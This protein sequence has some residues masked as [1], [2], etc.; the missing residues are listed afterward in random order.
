MRV[1]LAQVAPALGNI[2]AN[3][4]MHREAT[5]KAIAA[6][7]DLIVFPELSLTGYLLQDLV[8]E[9]ALSPERSPEVRE[10]RRLSRRIAIVFGFVEESEDHRFYNAAL[11]LA[12]GRILHRHRKVYL[13]TYGM[14]E[15]GREFAAGGGFSA[16]DTP[17]GRFGILLCEDAWHPSSAYL[18][19]QDGADYLLVLSSGPSRGV[20]SG[21]EL[22]STMDWVDL[23]RVT[24]RFQTL[25]VVYVNRVGVEDGLHF[26]GGSFAADP[27]GEPGRRAPALKETI[28]VV[29]LPREALRRARTRFPLLR[30]EKPEVVL[31][32]L[33]RILRE[34]PRP[35]PAGRAGVRGAPA[36]APP[37]GRG[38]AK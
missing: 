38:R 35:G 34:G 32:E 9:V 12:G 5:R 25:F 14:F 7:A 18:L 28:H 3:L 30:D 4:K 21:A 1:A 10:M 11:F 24:A 2:E 33:S 23:C 19:A 15:E 20:G 29:N 37:P 22:A 6:G 17:L 27:S 36:E 26:S 13:P 8:P 16:F 31:S